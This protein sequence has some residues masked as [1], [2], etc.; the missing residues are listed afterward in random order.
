M[1][2]APPNIAPA[3]D[4]QGYYYT[5]TI[6]PY[7]YWAIEYGYKEFSG[8]ESTEFAKVAARGTEPALQYATDED[9][10]L[11]QRPAG[12]PVRS[13]AQSDGF[14]HSPDEAQHRADAQDARTLGQEG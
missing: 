13:G 9:V 14:R 10:V 4:T 3:G 8:S 5:P 12:Q 2:Y 6:G 7:D 11:R 1:D